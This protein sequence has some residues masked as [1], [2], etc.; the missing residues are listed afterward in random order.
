MIGNPKPPRKPPDKPGA[1]APGRP[2]HE[3]IIEEL[4]RWINSPGLQPPTGDSTKD[5][6]NA[7]PAVA[8]GLS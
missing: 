5:E 1:P 6:R 3:R 4:D 2:S 8:P 7:R